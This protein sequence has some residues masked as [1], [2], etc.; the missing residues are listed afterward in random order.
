[1]KTPQFVSTVFACLVVLGSAVHA[2]GVPVE[3]VAWGVIQVKIERDADWSMN[4]GVD[5]TMVGTDPDDKV[6]IVRHSGPH[7]D[8]CVWE[9]YWVKDAWGK[10]REHDDRLLCRPGKSKVTLIYRDGH[11]SQ[12]H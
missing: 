5:V 1:M 10:L 8:V 6:M 2:D 4:P 9:G 3:E 11:A 7:P 12:P